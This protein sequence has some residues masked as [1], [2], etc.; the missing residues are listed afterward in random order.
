M[1]PVASSSIVMNVGD[2]S[3]LSN[4]VGSACRDDR[5][6]V[7]RDVVAPDLTEVVVAAHVLL[8]VDVTELIDGH[9]VE[10]AL[11]F[12]AVEAASR[13]CRRARAW[14]RP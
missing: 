4:S 1:M 14:W 13:R 11:A 8:Q 7:A 2:E 3:V 9:V 12:G 6:H 10:H 5:E